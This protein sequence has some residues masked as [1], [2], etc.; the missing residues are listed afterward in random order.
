MLRAIWRWLFGGYTCDD[1]KTWTPRRRGRADVRVERREVPVPPW[2]HTMLL[3][4]VVLRC[5]PCARAEKKREADAEFAEAFRISQGKDK[6]EAKASVLVGL[7]LSE[8]GIA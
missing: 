5:P 6:R 4:F 3:R 8:G 7:L 1:C 2:P